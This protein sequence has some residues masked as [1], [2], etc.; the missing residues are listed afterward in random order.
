MI[1]A[2][3]IEHFSE[4][5]ELKKTKRTTLEMFGNTPLAE[6][7]RENK[8]VGVICECLYIEYSTR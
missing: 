8:I 1:N 5:R 4:P 6:W 3:V 2:L 7:F